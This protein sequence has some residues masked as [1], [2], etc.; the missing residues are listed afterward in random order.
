MKMEDLV[1]KKRVL[2]IIAENP[3][4]KILLRCGYK[5]KGAPERYV[6][7]LELTKALDWAAASDVE[8]RE[9]EIYINSLSENDLW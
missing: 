1:S 6:D 2:E 8:I 3:G 5:F 9:N 7:S 4:K